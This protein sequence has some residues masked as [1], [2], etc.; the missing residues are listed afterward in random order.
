MIL[1]GKVALVTGGSRGIGRAVVRRLAS[2]GAAVAINYL[3][4]AAGAEE[5]AS[6][7]R[8]GGG[9]ALPVRADVGSES[10]VTAML[11]AVLAGL[12]P[13]DIL[14]NN[15]GVSYP[16][17]L[18]HLDPGQ[19]DQMRRTNLDGV[20]HT[21]RAVAG[22]MKERRF[23]RIVNVTS[24]AAY[25]TTM[26]GTTYYAATKAAVM[27]LTRRFAMELGP[28]G[29]TVNA[30][31]P[32]FVVTDMTL[33][34]RSPEQA[35]AML[36]EV[37]G[38]AM[39]RRVGRPEDIAHAVAFLASPESGFVTAQTLVVDGGRMDYISHG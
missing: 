31:A 25:G 9:S 23:G 39:M 30:V 18:G 21:T 29:I 7:I 35:E 11:E 6:E 28:Y 3:R 1:K 10:E 15:A 26:R 4:S 33:Q 32:G 36:N 20:L 27:L 38:L 22:P 14:V 34:G 37:A 12:G 13:V 16:S 2:Q 24:I 19:A 8:N 17:D 5:L